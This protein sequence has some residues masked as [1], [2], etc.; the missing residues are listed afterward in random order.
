M[1]NRTI[2]MRESLEVEFKSDKRKLDDGDII[3]A[4]VGGRLPKQLMMTTHPQRWTDNS[5][6]W[7]KEYVLQNV[8]NEVKKRMLWRKR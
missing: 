1:M 2:P 8:K 6:H 5:I 4:V 3:D 7:I